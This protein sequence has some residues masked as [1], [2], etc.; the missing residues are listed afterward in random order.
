MGVTMVETL[1]AVLLMSVVVT[2]V[3]S[4]A[5]SSRVAATKTSRKGIAGFYIRRAQEKLKPYVTADTTLGVEGP[6]GTGAA[7][8]RLPEDACAGSYGNCPANCDAL[9][10]CTHDVTAML[11]GGL[12][13]API[14]MRMT[15]TV[16]NAGTTG[17][18]K[19][20]FDVSWDQ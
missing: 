15:Y 4:L 17:R 10:V 12:T 3:F 18:K 13:G 8:W 16:T 7:A 14:N 9:D 2:S 19:V 6:G 1:V 11:P 5:L 20:A